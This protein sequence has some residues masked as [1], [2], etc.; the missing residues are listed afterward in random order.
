MFIAHRGNNGMGFRENSVSAFINCFNTSYIDGV[1]MDVR[2]TLDGVVV[3]S[4]SDLIN[5]KV[6]SKTKYSKLGIDSLDYVLSSLSNKKKII[7][8]VKGNDLGIIDKLYFVLIKYDY[9]FY[10]CSFNYDIVSL[11]KK[12]YSNYKIGLIIGYMLNIDKI[13]N[14][15]DFNL[16]HY[17]L[18]KRIGNKESFI[19]TVNDRFVYDIVKKYSSFI[20]TDKAYLLHE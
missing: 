11:F 13:H 15:F 16:I 19:W 7:I 3:V 6:I 12:R 1:E 4:H 9:Q 5:G 14:D 17:N 18:F 2:L 10:I 20:I 8:D